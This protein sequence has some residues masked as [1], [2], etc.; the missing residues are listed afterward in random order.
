MQDEQRETIP[1]EL[2]EYQEYLLKMLL[3]F[4][5]FCKGNGLSYFLAGGSALGAYRHQGFIP[6]DDDIDLAMLRPDFERLE[7][8]LAKQGNRLEVYRYSPVEK[9]IIP[10]APIGHLLYLPEGTY[11]Q[12]TAPKL[13]I[14]P[15]DGVPDGKAGRLLQRIFVIVHYLSVYRLPTKNKGKAAHEIS[16]IIVKITPDRLFN[17]YARVSKK[18]ITA[19]KTEDADKVC[20]LFG[21][22]GYQREVMDKD[23]LLPYQRVSFCGHMLPV[24]NQI[25]PYLQQLYGDYDRLPPVEDRQPKHSGYLQFVQAM[26]QKNGETI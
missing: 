9:Q 8:L 23:I 17:W 7:Q 2:K 12:N 16:K 15:I 24:P 6:W 4:D 19:K 25:Q 5:T 10:D 13:D 22:A 26:R 18:I 14:H 11:P 1:Q 20:S 3:V 21:L